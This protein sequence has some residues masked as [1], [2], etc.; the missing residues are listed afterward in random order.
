M[1]LKGIFMFNNT[2]K[3]TMIASKRVCISKIRELHYKTSKIIFM[4]EKSVN[5]NL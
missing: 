3:G 1:V 4:A 5:S 2:S